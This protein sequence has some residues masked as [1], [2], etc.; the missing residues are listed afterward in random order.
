[1]SVSIRLATRDDAAA[2]AAIY[3]PHV[4]GGVAS[5]ELVPPDVE[6]LAAR[7][8]RTTARTPWLVA[9]EDGRVIGYAYAG[10][11]RERAGY[12]WTAE[13]TV[14]VDADRI[15]QGIGRRLMGAVLDVLRRQGFHLVVAGVTM[16]NDASVGL[17]LAL[18]FRR[19]GRYP[20]IGWK[21]GAWWDTEW[22]ALKL[23]ERTPPQPITP[24]P[25]LLAAGGLGVLGGS[26]GS[27]TG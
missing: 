6:E 7:I 20:A 27:A 19:V 25:E 15:G 14:Y 16:P 26:S 22:F 8:E 11:H 18:G 10:R 23:S 9:E 4:E 1:M 2:C 21:D 12:D 13:S 5:F 3:R 17:H 24:L